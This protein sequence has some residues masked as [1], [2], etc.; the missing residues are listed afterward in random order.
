MAEIT[1]EKLIFTTAFCCMASDGTI[2][3]REIDLLKS[4]CH[5]SKDLFNFKFEDEINSLIT[6]LNTKGKE[7]ISQYFDMLSQAQLTE[8]E[9]I[10][11]IDYALKIIKADQQIDYSEISFFKVI[12]H[13]LTIGDEKI[14]SIFP[15]IEYFLE[16]DINAEYSLGKMVERYLSTSDLPKFELIQSIELNKNWIVPRKNG[17]RN[18]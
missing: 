14:L 1:F 4:M 18:E 10:S 11:L 16:E 9:E 5:E 3:Q 8:Q 17:D 6:E 2:D 15:D 13:H 7:F 12:R